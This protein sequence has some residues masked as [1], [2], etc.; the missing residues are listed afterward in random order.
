MKTLLRS[1]ILCI[2]LTIASIAPAQKTEYI[3]KEVKG[4]VEYRLKQAD[5]WKPAKR[6]LS[7]PKSSLIKITDGSGMTVYSQ[8]NPQTLKINTPGENRLRTLIDAAEK[9]A[10]KTR[11]GE[12]THVFKG[13]GEQVKT[14]RSGT[15]YRGMEDMAGLSSIA[16]AVLT[17]NT[18]DNASIGI[19]LAKDNEGDYGVELSN[20]SDTP[21]VFAVIININ[22][23]YNAL[24]ISDNP[25]SS[26]TLVIPAG[27]NLTLPECT[28]ADIEGMQPIAV[29]SKETF[30]PETLC[31]ILNSQAAVQNNDGT[32]IGA[33][34]VKALV[35]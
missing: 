4:N 18:S 33:V 14:L 28:L 29:A 8:S 7:I 3:I 12:L 17:A 35:P 31:L 1:I 24:H 20:N 23:K 27:V 34:A 32:D 30:D 26:S 22:G 10:A 15:S 25:A 5:E 21:L 19:T 9:K 2:A 6:L 16:A 13:Y 11:G